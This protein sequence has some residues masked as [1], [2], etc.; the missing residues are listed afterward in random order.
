MIWTILFW[1]VLVG[2]G[3]ALFLAYQMRYFAGFALRNA[4]TA[5]DPELTRREALAIVADAVTGSLPDD[6]A[7]RRVREAG[8]HLIGTY[9]VQLGYIRT[10]R[11]LCRTLPYALAG[12]LAARWML[13]GGL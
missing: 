10:S 3:F 6:T 4:I 12:L 11:L 13:N 1:T 8:Q 9:P 5:R 7:T 2:A